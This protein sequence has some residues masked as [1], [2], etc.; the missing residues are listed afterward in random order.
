MQHYSCRYY[1]KLGGFA[2][3]L[4]GNNPAIRNLHEFTG[5]EVW[6]STANVANACTALLTLSMGLLG[7]QFGTQYHETQMK[8][9][10]ICAV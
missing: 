3:R 2:I 7:L 6:R 8:A 9:T 1:Y 4:K 5:L 10:S